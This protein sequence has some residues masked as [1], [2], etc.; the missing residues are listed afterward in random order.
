MRHMKKVFTL[1]AAAA[2]AAS[3]SAQTVTESKSY[4]NWYIGV[5][6]GVATKATGHA[7]LKG[8]QPNAGLRVG[9]YFTPVLGMAVESNAY[10]K[11]TDGTSTGTAVNALNTSML[12]TVNLS[13]WLGG[14][15]GEPRAFEVVALYGLGWGHVFGSPS[16]DY[17]FTKDVMTSKA[18]IDFVFNLGSSKAWQIYVEPAMV[19]SLGGSDYNPGLQYNLNHSAFQLNAGLVYKFRNSNGTHNFEVAQLRDQAEIDDMNDRINELRASLCDKDAQLSAKDRRIA[20]LTNALDD[21]NKKPKCVKPATATNL[22]PTVLF[23]QGKSVIDP[24]QY[25]PVEL[26]AQYMRNHPEA[27]VEIVGYASPEGTAEFNQRLSELRAEAVK[28]ALVKKYKISADRLTTKG[29]GA[30]DELFE[31]VE[32]NRVATFNDNAK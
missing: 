29:K 19:W 11:N 4:D 21:C 17:D 9:R 7:W 14:Y 5:N 16:E 24:A 28:Q 25:A 22:Q 26:I 13:N 15:P 20:E 27:K 10:F 2:M 23:R 18:G 30:T 3:V 8:M 1:I 31:Q 32:F 12:G 6:G